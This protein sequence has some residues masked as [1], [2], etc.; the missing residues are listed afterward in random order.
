MAIS[1]QVSQYNNNDNKKVYS[2]Q[3][4]TQLNSTRLDSTRLD[5][6]K[7]TYRKPSAASINILSDCHTRDASDGLNPANFIFSVYNPNLVL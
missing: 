1:R 7:A 3:R 2:T 6:I 4:Y 5:S